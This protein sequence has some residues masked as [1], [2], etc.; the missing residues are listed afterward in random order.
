MSM[1]HRALVLASASPRRREILAQL[2]LTFRVL[3]SGVDESQLPDEAPE[4]HVERLARSK[5]LEIAQQLAGEPARACVLAA[6]T[7]VVI[8]GVILGKPQDDAE[9]RRMLGALSGRTHREWTAVAVADSGQGLRESALFETAVT[10]RRLDA[11]SAAA[12][13]SSG[14]GRDKAGSYAIQGLGAGLVARIAGSYTNVV[15]LP[16][17]ETLDMLQRAGVF[18]VWP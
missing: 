3:P 15:G 7:V 17:V 12:Y 16:A 1:Q 6:D 9:G 4:P 10:F 11:R 8:D 5:A 18:E 13:V 14:E 2:G